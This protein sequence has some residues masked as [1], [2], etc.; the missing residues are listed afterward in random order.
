MTKEADSPVA[1]WDPDEKSIELAQALDA[2]EFFLVYQPTIDLQTNAFVGV[3]ALIRW[4][5]RSRGVM[6][7]GTFIPELE[8]SGQIIRVGQWALATACAQ[9]VAWHDKG[10]RFAVSLNISVQEFEDQGF[11]RW[12]DD[13]LKA[14][15]FEPSLLILEFPLSVISRDG[16]SVARTL[17]DLRELGV[18]LAIDDFVPND[19]ALALLRAVPI[20]TIKLDRGFI[21]DIAN[22]PTSSELVQQLVEVTKDRSLQIIASGIEDTEQRERLKSDHVNVGQGFLF[23]MP[24]DAGEIDLFL[25]DFSIFSG[26]PI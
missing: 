24:R 9:G 13:T 23:S 19:S 15:G 11:I 10:Y 12:V 7:P 8:T 18:R 21:A 26:K 16:Q 14:S 1:G 25:E 2:N 5:H 3:E 20:T 4:R 22:S 17:G 6:S